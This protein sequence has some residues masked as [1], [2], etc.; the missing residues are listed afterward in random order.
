MPVVIILPDQGGGFRSTAVT[1]VGAGFSQQ[2]KQ[3][4]SPGATPVHLSPMKLYALLPLHKFFD[5]YHTP[6]PTLS[7]E[8]AAVTK[9]DRDA[10]SSDVVGTE[11]INIKIIHINKRSGLWSEHL[12]SPPKNSQ[13]EIQPPSVMALGGGAFGR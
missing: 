4:G 10:C 5:N 2:I 3:K 8:E 1:M 12:C 9:M 13:V 11:V 7:V 6:G